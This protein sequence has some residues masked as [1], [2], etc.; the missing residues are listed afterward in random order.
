MMKNI[1]FSQES[2]PIMIKL[3][4][5][6]NVAYERYNLSSRVCPEES[7]TKK[8]GQRVRNHAIQEMKVGS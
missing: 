6:D 1:L 5:M 7:K 8:G 2:Q 4:L 3:D